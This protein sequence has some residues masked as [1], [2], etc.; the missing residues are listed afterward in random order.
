MVRCTT[1][2][3]NKMA[4]AILLAEV[5]GWG[6]E[7]STTPALVWRASPFPLIVQN[8]SRGIRSGSQTTPACE[9]R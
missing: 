5:V 8:S 3:A 6:N 4:A 7:T 1:T 2:S 9:E